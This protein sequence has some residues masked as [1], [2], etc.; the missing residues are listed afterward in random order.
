MLVGFK[1]RDTGTRTPR[2]R[3]IADV[4]APGGAVLLAADQVVGHGVDSVEESDLTEA[5]LRDMWE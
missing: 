3:A 1:A 5:V 4:D 2:P